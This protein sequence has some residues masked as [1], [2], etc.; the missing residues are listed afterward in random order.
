MSCE[1]DLQAI[2]EEVYKLLEN[3]CLLRRVYIPVIIVDHLLPHDA[4]RTSDG[5]CYGV[6]VCL[7]VC[8]IRGARQTRQTYRQTFFTTQVVPAF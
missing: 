2:T 7:S 1:S 5:K 8:H 3:Q 6:S 4:L